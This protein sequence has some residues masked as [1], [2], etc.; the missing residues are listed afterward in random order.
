M[1]ITQQGVPLFYNGDNVVMFTGAKQ[2]KSIQ[3]YQ[4]L[5][6][7]YSWYQENPEKNHLGLMNLWGQQ[8]QV[9]YPIYREL[10]ANKAMIEVNG[11]DGGFTYDIPIEEYKG[12]YTTRD[13]SF[14]PFP[15]IDG[16]SFKIVLNHEYTT[17]DVLTNDAYRGQQIIV[18]GEEPVAQVG[19]GFEHTVKLVDQDKETWFLPSNLS[20]GVSYI[21]MN[22]AVAGEY[23]TNFS[24]VEMPDTVGT[25]RCEFKLGSIRGVEA[26]VT[27]MADKKSFSGAAM[28]SQSKQFLNKLQAEVDS[29]GELAVLMDTTTNAKGQKTPNWATMRIGST[30]EWLVQRELEKLTAHAL[31]FQKAG[32]IRDGNGNYRLNEGLWHQLRRGKVIKYGRPGGITRVHLKEAVEYIFRNNPWKKVEERR[33]KFK[34]GK[35]AVANVKEIF[36]EEAKNQL[37]LLRT[38]G[39][40]GDTRPLPTT[41]IYNAGGGNDLMNLGIRPVGFTEIYVPDIGILEIEEDPSL[42]YSPIL[43][44]RFARGMHGEQMADTAYSL[45]IWDVADKQYSNNDELPKGATFVDGADRGSNIFLVKPEGA[46]TYW[47]KS[48]GRYDYNK[49]GDIVSSHKQI[50][51]EFWAWNS[52]AIWVKDITRF[53]MIELDDV[54]RKGYN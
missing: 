12:C 28:G 34:G 43:Q 53:I 22:H 2:I 8:A 49:A 3:G 37:D 1:S 39:L 15:G 31:L 7:L 54:A 45:V 20:K 4:D 5:P 27:G 16:S 36:A 44:D 18:S 13:M 9:N 21:K 32:T 24:H 19:D 42:N 47:G 41:P 10:I 14:Q 17:G 25:M 38:A 51:Q 40:L 35:F 46:M 23:G 30:M 29:L 11:F 26:Y 48:N 6:S 52:I 50:G 33:I